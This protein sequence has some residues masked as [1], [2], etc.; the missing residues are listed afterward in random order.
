[1]TPAQRNPSFTQQQLR[2]LMIYFSVLIIDTNISP[3]V[4]HTL[5]CDVTNAS[6]KLDVP[7]LCLQGIW[8]KAEKLLTKKEAI[9]PAPGQVPEARMVLSYSGKVPHMV[10]P[11]KSRS[12]CC[13]SSCVNWKSLD[14]CSH[15]VAVAEVNGKLYLFVR[16]R[17]SQ[18]L[19]VVD[20]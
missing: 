1:M 6:E 9:V 12:F 2:I 5:S 7:L 10:T 4:P 17:K 16:R 13:D 18:I 8:S 14:I 20:H 15:T 11:N 19:L 3:I